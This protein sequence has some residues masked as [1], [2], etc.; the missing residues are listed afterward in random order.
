MGRFLRERQMVAEPRTTK[1]SPANH[2]A[3]DV[4]IES[5]GSGDLRSEHWEYDPD[6]MG[7]TAPRRT[8]TVTAS[9]T[10]AGS[11]LIQRV[12]ISTN[13]ALNEFSSKYNDKEK[14]RVWITKVKSAF[15]RDQCSDEEKCIT[16]ADLL[17]GPTRNRFRQLAFK[18][19]YFGQGVSI[20]WPYYHARKRSDETPLEYLHRLNVAGMRARVKV[21]DGDA[22]AR[23][24]HVEH[25]VETM[26]A[27]E[28]A[29]QLTLL[30]LE[31]ADQL[32]E[33]RQKKSIGSNKY[34]T[35]TPTP[36]K[37]AAVH[38]V[39]VQVSDSGSDSDSAEPVSGSEGGL[40]RAFAGAVSEQT[41]AVHHQD[42]PQPLNPDQQG[43][44]YHSDLR[45]WKRLTC[46]KCG[47]KGHPSDR[48]FFVCRGWG[49]LHDHGKCQMEEFYNLTR[50]WFNPKKHPG[51]LPEAAEKMLN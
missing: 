36:T 33:S 25:F 37:P 26:G 45:C 5:V 20:A 24:E 4:E 38:V 13:S 39:Q 10:A 7:A 35:K 15:T 11:A 28:L 12:R 43:Q 32:E 6:D 23:R 1:T 19:Q 16:F 17:T 40:R 27:L 22:K 51:L 9:A 46:Q 31:D 14:A 29:D 48:F 49:Q 3:H 21:K 2:G 30:R 18:S 41:L 42:P 8:A 44:R 34:R 47:K 50:Q